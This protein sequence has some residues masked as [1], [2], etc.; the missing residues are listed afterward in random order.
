MVRIEVAM[1]REEKRRS[2][3]IMSYVL[4]DLEQTI[5][6]ATG[7]AGAEGDLQ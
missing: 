1:A 3:Y 7:D 6:H 5:S 4:E 2:D